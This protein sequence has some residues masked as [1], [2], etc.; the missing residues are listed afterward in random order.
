MTDS[1]RLWFGENVCVR[2]V[3]DRTGI[4]QEGKLGSSDVFI[5]RMDSSWQAAR[6]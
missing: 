6:N 4:L 2:C 1:E 5:C 3:K